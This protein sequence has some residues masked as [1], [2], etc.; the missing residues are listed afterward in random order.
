MSFVHSRTHR[1]PAV[2]SRT[3]KR[4]DAPCEYCHSV[5]RPKEKP[6]MMLSFTHFAMT[7]RRMTNDK[8][9]WILRD[10]IFVVEHKESQ[11]NVHTP[12]DLRIIMLIDILPTYTACS[13]LALIISGSSQEIPCWSI[14]QIDRDA[15]L[16]TCRV[17]CAK[18]IRAHW[19]ETLCG[20]SAVSK[21]LGVRT[22]SLW[23]RFEWFAFRELE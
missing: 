20:T 1:K 10:T 13:K 9:R 6:T 12:S 2:K 18:C 22:E 14:I 17:G 3:A 19:L 21:D 23:R 11:L 5:L 8:E 15:Q 7:L 4:M 16:P